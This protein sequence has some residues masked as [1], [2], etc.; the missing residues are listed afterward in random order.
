MAVSGEVKNVKTP[1]NGGFMGF[2]RELKAELK[3]ITWPSKKDI[4]KSTAT[5]I[6]FCVIFMILIGIMDLGFG[7][8]FKLI[9][10]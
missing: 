10:K 4:K 1:S 2:F 8:L 9:Y 6:T 7:R 5:V 3:R